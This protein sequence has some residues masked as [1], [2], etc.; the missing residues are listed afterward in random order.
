M[1]I[2]EFLYPLETD[3]ALLEMYMTAVA[4]AIVRCRN[5]ERGGKGERRGEGRGGEGRGGEGRRGRGG[6]GKGGEG[7]GGEG[8]GGEGRGRKGGEEGEG[9]GGEGRRGGLMQPGTTL[10]N[11]ML[12][13]P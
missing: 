5:E 10:V 6:E 7:R 12:G 4:T 9:K 8:K 11:C 13:I 2:E 3:G 1:K